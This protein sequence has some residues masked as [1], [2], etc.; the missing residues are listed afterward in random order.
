MAGGRF[1]DET[2]RCVFP[3]TVAAVSDTATFLECDLALDPV[4]EA[5]PAAHGYLKQLD[6]LFAIGLG[7]HVRYRHHRETVD[8]L[9][10]AITKGRTVQMRY[11]SAGWNATTR[12]EVDPYRVWY[13]QGGLYLMAY[14][15]R[16]REVRLFKVVDALIG[17]EGMGPLL[18][19]PVEMGLVLAGRDLVAVDA[20]AGRVMGFA[21]EKVPITRAA[22][23]HPCALAF[24]LAGSLGSRPPTSPS[25]WLIFCPISRAPNRLPVTRPDVSAGWLP[26][27]TNPRGETGAA[28]DLPRL[29]IARRRASVPSVRQS[30]PRRIP[31]RFPGVMQG[32]RYA[33]P[34]VRRNPSAK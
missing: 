18:G 2:V 15:H 23:D 4:R 10:E 25:L 27:R 29:A 32:R 16:R 3:L 11:F 31:V 26:R 13:A 7:P 20:I 21:S 8:Q 24:L 1:S 17:Q 14:C 19:M 30:S 28:P 33:N 5:D 34:W 9:A 12:R 6:G 22:V